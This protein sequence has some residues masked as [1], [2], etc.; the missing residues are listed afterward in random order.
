MVLGPIMRLKLLGMP[1]LRAAKSQSTEMVLHQ[2]QVGA[3]RKVLDGSQ[4]VL[5][6]FLRT[7]NRTRGDSVSCSGSHRGCR[8]VGFVLR[9]TGC[10]VATSRRTASLR[11]QDGAWAD[12]PAHISRSFAIKPPTSARQT[13]YAGSS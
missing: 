13:R 7:H 5:T 6:T 3:Y 9:G 12:D 8:R 10:P 4:G 2:R 11:P 1:G